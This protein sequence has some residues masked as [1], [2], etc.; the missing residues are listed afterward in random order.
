M[1]RFA[2]ARMVNFLER[3]DI[4]GKVFND[5][6]LGSYLIFRRWPDEKVFIDGRTPVYG[7]DFYRRYIEAFHLAPHF[8]Q[9]DQEYGF[10]YLVFKASDAWDIRHVHKY[11]W[12][13]PKWR[14][15][16]M[17]ADGI[18]YLRYGP[19][20]SRLIKKLELTRNPLMEE[21]EKQ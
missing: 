9:L 10:D 20:F 16:Y 17:N 3:H 5:M 11:L 2:P 13:K 19:R 15:V 4:G 8:E 6:A 12:K 18:V 1:D 21:I 14:L 7:D